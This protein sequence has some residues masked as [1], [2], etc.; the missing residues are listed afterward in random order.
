VER[1]IKNK[2]EISYEG[3]LR[4]V[5]DYRNGIPCRGYALSVLDNKPMPVKRET[6]SKR[7]RTDQIYF[8]RESCGSSRNEKSRRE[9]QDQ[10]SRVGSVRGP[11]TAKSKKGGRSHQSVQTGKMRTLRIGLYLA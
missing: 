7:Q 9:K 3:H 1:R 8:P 5:E 2:K 6:I 11:G 4:M 10:K